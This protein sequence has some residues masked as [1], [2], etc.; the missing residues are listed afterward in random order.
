MDVENIAEKVALVHYPVVYSEENW[1]RTQPDRNATKRA[2]FL[3][4]WDVALKAVADQAEN[5]TTK[6][7]VLDIIHNLKHST[8]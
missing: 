2:A 8:K 1:K 5:A 3:K 4:G 7:D 6:A